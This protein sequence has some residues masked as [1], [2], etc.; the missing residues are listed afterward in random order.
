MGT[1]KAVDCWAKWG[2]N[3]STGGRL[4]APLRAASM[5]CPCALVFDPGFVENKT[6]QLGWPNHQ[7]LN[8]FEK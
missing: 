1:G 8:I 4:P 3:V 7:E 5:F 6:Q 2:T